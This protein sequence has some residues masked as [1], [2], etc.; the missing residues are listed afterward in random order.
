[1]IY[2]KCQD[3]ECIR[4][5]TLVRFVDQSRTETVKCDEC[6]KKLIPTEID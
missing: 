5:N 6:K 2:Y 3:V 1:M 4:K